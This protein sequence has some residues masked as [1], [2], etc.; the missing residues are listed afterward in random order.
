MIKSVTVKNCY[1]EQVKIVLADA[2]PS[3]KMFITSISGLGPAKA[4]VNT[5]RLATTDGSYFNS[6]LLEPRNIVIKMLFDFVSMTSVEEARLNTYKYFPIKR[7]VELIIETD[8][9]KVKTVGY[10][11]SNEPDIF[12]S[13]ESNSISIICPDPFFYDVSDGE[14]QTISFASIT[15]LFEFPIENN[16]LTEDLLSFGSYEYLNG[17]PLYYK[18]DVDIGFVATI[19]VLNE[20]GDI[21]LSNETTGQSV[22]LYADRLDAFTGDPLIAGDVVTISSVLGSKKVTL[23]RNGKRTNI[24]NC[25][26]ADSDWLKLTRGD[27]YIK[28]E[29]DNIEDVELAITHKTVYEGV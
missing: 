24:L 19:N 7:D 4:N 14:N 17:Y 15:D 25:I 10:V 26:G 5:T 6:A 23:I 29:A 2:E 20:L 27:N 22:T 3:H 18:G 8:N 13:D 1:G 12:S 16:S 21:T 28:I 9:R 11:E